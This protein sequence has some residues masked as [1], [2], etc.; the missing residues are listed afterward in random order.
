MIAATP[1]ISRFFG[2]VLKMFRNDHLP[3]HFHAE[4][5]EHEALIEKDAVY[6]GDLPRRALVLV[7]ETGRAAPRTRARLGVSPNRATSRLVRDTGKRVV[8]LAER[9]SLP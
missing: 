6:P 4:H 9:R 3:P 8:S 7:L 2:I 1:E 5:G